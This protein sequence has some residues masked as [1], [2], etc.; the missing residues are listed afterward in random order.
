MAWSQTVPDIKINEPAKEEAPVLV[1]RIVFSG[2]VLSD[3]KHLEQ[4]IKSNQNK[5]LSREQIQQIIDNVK[6]LYLEAGFAKLTRI[7]YKVQ[8][9]K[10]M[11]NVSLDK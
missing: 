11:I 8:K 7:D 4:I 1:R 9:N 10:L 5:Y 6:I 2:L 3:R